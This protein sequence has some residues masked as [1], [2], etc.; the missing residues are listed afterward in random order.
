MPI[1]KSLVDRSPGLTRPYRA[2]DGGLVRLRLPGGRITSET[3]RRLADVSAE[4]AD[5]L[6]QLTRRGNIQLR[7]MRL[8]ND[9]SV[10]RRAANALVATGI[11]PFS[12]E[13]VRTILCSPLPSS[14]RPDLHPMAAELDA[15]ILSEPRLADLLGSFVWALDDGSGDIAAERWDL[16]YQ[17]VTPLVGIVATST[18]EAWEVLARQAVPTLIGLAGEFVKLRSQQDP[19]PLHPHQLGFKQ[20]SRFGTRLSIELGPGTTRTLYRGHA[21]HVGPVGDDLLAGVPLGLLFPEMIEALPP[22]EITLTPWRQVL[23]P[24]GAYDTAAFRAAGYAIDPTEPW[25]HVT[26]CAGAL[27]CTRTEVDTLAMA[28]RLVDAVNNGE[29]VLTEDL[30]ISGCERLCGAPRADHIDVVNPHHVVVA[31]DEIEERRYR[32]ESDDQQ[33]GADQ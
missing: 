14:R 15:A 29:A 2:R 7:A 25:A 9:G 12:H 11:V 31:I 20:R 21:R 13:R 16:C 28:E 1:P 10:Y 33:S 22:G 24:G 8:E 32:M 4:H 6:L 19:P 5:G 18:G 17:A 26:A 23:V 30:H 27:G 3:L